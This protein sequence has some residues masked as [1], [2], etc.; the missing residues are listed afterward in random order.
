M[1]KYDGWTQTQLLV[2]LQAQEADP[3]NKN[4]DP[5]RLHLYTPAAQRRMDA[6]ALAITLEMTRRKYGGD[7]RDAP[8]HNL[9]YSGRQ[10]S[11]R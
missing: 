8:F 9:G 6:L 4:T 2:E 11:R 3:K 7:G 10:T 5:R 1:G